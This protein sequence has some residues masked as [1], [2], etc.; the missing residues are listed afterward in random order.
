MPD[1]RKKIKTPKHEIILDVLY[2][3]IS[4]PDI[5]RNRD[6]FFRMCRDGCRNFNSKYSC[7]PC[8]P[9]FSRYVSGYDSAFVV[10][11]K[12]DLSQLSCYKDYHRLRVGNA[13]IKPRIERIMR[14]LEKD[15]GG[16]FLSTGA[17][18]LCKP[19]CKKKGMPCKNPESMRYSLESMGVDCSKLSEK[20]FG[21]ELK[22]YHDKT[23]P[24]YTS[25]ISGLAFKDKNRESIRSSFEMILSS[26]K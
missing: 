26:M 5:P 15:V 23:A 19:C 20:L 21:L 22:W 9:E 7:P 17:C 16:R 6:V 25:V 11:I 24:E 1:T 3:F 14:S 2:D 4:I 8:S 18:R 10:L 13:V 12:V